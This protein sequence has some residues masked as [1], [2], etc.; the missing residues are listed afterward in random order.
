MKRKQ[1]IVASIILLSILGS[2]G[3]GNTAF[4]VGP[5]EVNSVVTGQAKIMTYYQSTVQELGK[6][7]KQSDETT[8]F[9]LNTGEYLTDSWIESTDYPGSFY[10]V[11]LNGLITEYTTTI[12]EEHLD[13]K[14][15]YESTVATI[16]KWEQQSDGTRKFKLNTGGYLVDGWV[17]SRDDLANFYFLGPKGWISGSVDTLDEHSI[18]Q[19]KFK[20]KAEQSE[21][22]NEEY[23]RSLDEHYLGTGVYDKLPWNANAK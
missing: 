19:Y 22:F 1:V 18:D 20:A 17:E 3:N 14:I 4:A 5:G 21:I 8:K 16:G 2:L 15:Y 7:E 11:D 9:K 10:Y 6:W 13:F 23:Y 12:G